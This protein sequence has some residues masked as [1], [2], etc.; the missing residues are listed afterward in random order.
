MSVLLVIIVLGL[1]ALFSWPLS[2]AMTWAMYPAGNESVLRKR[3]DVIFQMVGGRL[4]NEE[5][6]WKSYC[7]S[8][9][10]FNAAMFAIVYIILS[11]QQYLPLNPNSKG[12]LEP[13]LVFNIVASFTTNTNLQH[14]SGE[15]AMSY[16]SQVFAL[17]W[18][19]FVSAATG[20]AA[21]AALARSL[22]GNIRIG[23]FYRDLLSATFL[24]LLPLAAVVAVM[25]VFS[26]V[27]MTLQGAAVAK[28]LEG[29]VQSIARGPVAAMVAIKQ[30]GTNGGGFFGPNSTHPFENPLFFTNIVECV[31]IIL[32]PMASVWMFGRIIGRM[33]HAAVIFGVMAVLL[34]G[35]VS[36]AVYLEDAPT[37]AFQG[38][39]VESSSENLEGKELRFGSSAGALWAAVT[40]ATSNGSVNCMHDSL[41][42]LTALIPLIGMWLNVIF[43][44]VGVG[45][46]SMFI[47]IIIGVFICGMMVGR[48]PEY[49]TRKVETG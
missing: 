5:Q 15:V 1:A 13:S 12:A 37:A 7:L 30:L 25:L 43:G 47:Y 41:N 26:G 27:P 14:Y 9:M 4:V 49:L 44:G 34:I 6:D 11:V 17:M 29:A 45:L 46:I 10:I 2:Q 38:L 33:R 23:S 32:I 21:L 16:F 19:Q 42:P 20:I 36:L 28:T 18:L 22:A 8:L 24:V 35:N 3:I 40:T 48:T 39:S 31:S